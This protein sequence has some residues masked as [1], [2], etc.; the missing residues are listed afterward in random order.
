MQLII[1]IKSNEVA[2]EILNLL[3]GFK[4]DIKIIAKDDKDYIDLIKY[5]E[6][7]EKNPNE[8]LS[9]DQVDWDW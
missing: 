5:R 9:L 3:R 6:N 7:R 2:K 8:Y 1:D 4:S